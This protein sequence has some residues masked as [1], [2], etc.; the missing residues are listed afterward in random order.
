MSGLSDF[1]T[2]ATA[3]WWV[4]AASVVGGGIT[5]SITR[6][7]DNRK[8]RHATAA[9]QRRLEQQQAQLRRE[10]ISRLCAG[11]LAEVDALHRIAT[12]QLK[13]MPTAVIET[14]FEVQD[15]PKFDPMDS[16]MNAAE[17]RPER[18]GEV[19]QQLKP[20]GQLV[21]QLAIHAPAELTKA[22]LSL[23][24]PLFTLLFRGPTP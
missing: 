10:D 8:D 5:A 2:H 11:I 7:S 17:R 4:L 18:L 12:V 16:A 23:E 1:L 24:A 6:A 9:D 13:M 15:S 20:L 3:P 22:A 14:S 21:S 19:S